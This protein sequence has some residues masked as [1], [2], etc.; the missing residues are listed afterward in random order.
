MK[1]AKKCLSFLTVCMLVVG[2]SMTAYGAWNAEDSTTNYISTAQFGSEVINDYTP[3]DTLKPGEYVEDTINI[4]NIGS[5][6]TVVR[7]KLIKY[8]KA[9]DF[10]NSTIKLDL[11]LDHWYY[12]GDG[13]YYYKGYLNENEVTKYPILKGFTLDGNIPTSYMNEDAGI[14]AIVETTQYYGGALEELWGVTYEELGIPRPEDDVVEKETAHVTFT[15]DK[16]FEFNNTISKDDLFLNFKGLLPNSVRS[17]VITI[18]SE[19]SE[20]TDIYLSSMLSSDSN[21]MLKDLMFQYV[22]INI[23]TPSGDVLYNGAIGGDGSDSINL[24]NFKEG[25]IKDII[26]TA[27]VDKDMDVSYSELK[28]SVDWA[29][30]ADEVEQSLAKTGDSKFLLY[31]GLGLILSGCILTIIVKDKGVKES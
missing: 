3:P 1:R 13:Y 23:Q 2:F 12:N 6:S 14:D 18:K 28:G 16:S 26:V 7:V 9:E 15:K 17:Q 8:F 25:E 31:C 22:T 4:K 24:G 27:T 29:F 21:Q 10:D 11:D 20:P 30:K 5:T 19:C